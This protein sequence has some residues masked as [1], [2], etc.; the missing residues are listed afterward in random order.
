MRNYMK[1]VGETLLFGVKIIGIVLAIL[2]F[3]YL[4]FPEHPKEFF[5]IGYS[6]YEVIRNLFI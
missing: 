4:S 6:L 2:I 1:R 5:G 3:Y